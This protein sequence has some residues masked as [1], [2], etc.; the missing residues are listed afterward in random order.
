MEMVG[1][2]NQLEMACSENQLE[3]ASSENQLEMAGADMVGTECQLENMGGA[4]SQLEI[5][6]QIQMETVRKEGDIE[7]VS[8]EG[9]VER[10]THGCNFSGLKRSAYDMLAKNGEAHVTHKTA[11]PF[12]R[13]E[14]EKLAEDAGDVLESGFTHQYGIM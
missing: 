12:D 7:K 3:M 5:S 10:L 1:V 4:E 14:I 2:D 8:K 11:H 6:Q 9:S 13:W